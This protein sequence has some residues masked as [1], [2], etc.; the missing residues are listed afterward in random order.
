MA[1]G[2][3]KRMNIRVTPEMHEWLTK[4]ATMRG[5]TLNAMVIF[6]IETYMS[7]QMVLPHLEKMIRLQEQKEEKITPEEVADLQ[8][9]Y[10]DFQRKLE[11][12]D[13][14]D[15]SAKDSSEQKNS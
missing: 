9:Y 12:L 14:L 7:Q 11:I 13:S 8:Q 15:P 6:A 10:V 3:L 2:E 1:L 5:I 4:N